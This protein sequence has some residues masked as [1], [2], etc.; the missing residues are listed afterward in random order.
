MQHLDNVIDLDGKSEHDITTRPSFARRSTGRTITILTTRGP[1]MEPL[2]NASI[3]TYP[4]DLDT[5]KPNEHRG[6]PDSGNLRDNDSSDDGNGSQ[7]DAGFRDGPRHCDDIKP[8]DSDGSSKWT[9][10]KG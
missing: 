8:T 7:K 9:T 6:P 10:P 3:R 5:V 1:Y 4:W 2:R